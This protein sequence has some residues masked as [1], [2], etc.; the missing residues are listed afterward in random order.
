MHVSYNGEGSQ[1]RGETE[2]RREEK[3]KQKSLVGWEERYV[4]GSNPLVFYDRYIP[5]L[6]GT[7]DP[8]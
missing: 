4:Y 3:E 6:S 2:T 8:L 7:W 1:N 5:Y